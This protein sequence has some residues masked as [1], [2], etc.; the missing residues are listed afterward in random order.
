[1]CMTMIAQ[2]PPHRQQPFSKETGTEN[3]R[4][5]SILG[6][7]RF[8]R[9]H[10][11]PD[12]V[13]LE[14]R[15]R[16]VAHLRETC[17][18]HLRLFRYLEPLPIRKPDCEEDRTLQ[19]ISLSE[20]CFAPDR[21]VWIQMFPYL[22]IDTHY[23]GREATELEST[24]EVFGRL[25]AKLQSLN[26]DDRD[27]LRKN[28]C[29]NPL[30]G[31]RRT[32]EQLIRDW[33]L[34]LDAARDS[35]SQNPFSQILKAEK[36]LNDGENWCLTKWVNESAQLREHQSGDD[37]YPLLHDVHP[38]NVLCK[39][40]KCVLIY[41]YSWCGFWPHAWVV[42]FSLH[43]FVREYAIENAKTEILRHRDDS[44]H[45]PKVKEFVEKGM[46]LFLESY[47]HASG[48]DLPPLPRDFETNLGAYIRCSNMDKMLGAFEKG[49][50]LDE[51]IRMRPEER[52]LGEARKFVRFMKESEVF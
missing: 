7:P 38:H 24:A 19:K 36:E 9:I 47:R 10:R 39:D 15:S 37:T 22:D 20:S 34:I 29:K 8:I 11:F 51:E 42:A 46:H 6:L 25:Q 50:G 3:Y 1:M 14:C 32:G 40:S 5:F 48:P 27:Y 16:I 23:R 43:R 31:R 21:D 44:L 26:L 13:D 41:D 28:L 4:V 18:F 45:T 33:R 52:R 49:L 35:E 30:V 2:R 17:A 12:K